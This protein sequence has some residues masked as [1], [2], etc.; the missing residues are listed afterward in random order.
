MIDL[1]SFIPETQEVNATE[2][3]AKHDPT[4]PGFAE[5]FA[6]HMERRRLEHLSAALQE[7]K[8][9]EKKAPDYSMSKLYLSLLM[10][11][12]GAAPSIS[13]EAPNASVVM[14]E[15]LKTCRSG[16][17][18]MFTQDSDLHS[19]PQFPITKFKETLP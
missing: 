2:A 7:N 4:R 5:L 9:V 16:A 3:P 15:S 10:R 18:Q 14:L 6:E 11:L 1:L 17:R 13:P 8:D 12:G 19:M